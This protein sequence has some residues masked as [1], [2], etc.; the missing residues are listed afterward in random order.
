MYKFTTQFIF[1]RNSVQSG[2]A[3]R[4]HGDA[5]AKDDS[6]ALHMA[7]NPPLEALYLDAMGR[8]EHGL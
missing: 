2:R 3:L 8:L 4:A 1:Q 6:F 5:Q 7:E